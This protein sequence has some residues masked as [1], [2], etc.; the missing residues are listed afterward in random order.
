MEIISPIC[1][2]LII[3]E[4]IKPNT[5]RQCRIQEKPN[6]PWFHTKITPCRK[7]RP[8]SKP[9]SWKQG[10]NYTQVQKR[11]IAVIL[12]FQI[13]PNSFQRW[14]SFTLQT[15]ISFSSRAHV[16]LH[17][18]YLL[19]H[20]PLFSLPRFTTHTSKCPS[21]GFAVPTRI[22]VA[23]LGPKCRRTRAFSTLC[24]GLNPHFSA[25]QLPQRRR[26]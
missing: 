23:L 18:T 20:N 7:P 26:I 3:Y 5:L 12:Q 4:L 25:D 2:Q 14:R 24:I 13:Q 16:V 21:F 15:F 1:F 17:I 19:R 9:R 22:A 8:I 11:I 6:A 10:P